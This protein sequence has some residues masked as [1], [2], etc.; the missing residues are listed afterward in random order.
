MSTRELDLGQYVTGV[1]L[2]VAE[3]Q[4][5]RD[6]IQNF[7]PRFLTRKTSGENTIGETTSHE[8]NN[9]LSKKYSINKMLWNKM[10]RCS[11]NLTGSWEQ[12]GLTSERYGR[13][14]YKHDLRMEKCIFSLEKTSI[15]NKFKESLSLLKYR[16]LGSWLKLL[17]SSWTI[18]LIVDCI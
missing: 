18:W 2:L 7:Q 15:K 4:L 12:V 3:S 14:F 17:R 16:N 13:V 8:M 9:L 11:A 1:R 10:M 6:L 5:N